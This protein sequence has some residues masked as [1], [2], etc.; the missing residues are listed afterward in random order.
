MTSHYRAART[1]SRIVRIAGWLV[2]GTVIAVL[3][4]LM[5]SP[6]IS[7]VTVKDWMPVLGM[8]CI[9]AAII[10]FGYVCEAVFDIADASRSPPA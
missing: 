2:V 9:G 8:S 7:G 3:I 6:G 4:F 10:L 5:V 1:I